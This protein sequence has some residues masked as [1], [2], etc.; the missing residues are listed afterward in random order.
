[1]ELYAPMQ[2]VLEVEWET[3]PVEEEPA[4]CP[5]IWKEHATLRNG[6]ECHTKYMQVVKVK[7]TIQT[8]STHVPTLSTICRAV[9]STTRNNR[10]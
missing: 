7:T 4:G 2:Y 10:V 3:L 8:T 1:M 5:V 6:R 9:L